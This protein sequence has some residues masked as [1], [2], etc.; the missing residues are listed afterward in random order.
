MPA[1]TTYYLEMNAPS[2]LVAKSDANGLTIIECEESQFQFNR[3]LYQF[4]GG[5]WEWT[6]KLAW[7]DEQW[8]ELVESDAHRTFVAYFN[9]AIAGYFELYRPNDREV[10][11][12][13]FGLAEQFIG[14]GM[15]GYLLS[16]AI[17]SAWNWP[18]TE[19]VWVHTCSLD[20]PSALR[21]YQARGLKIYKEV[22]E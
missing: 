20:H 10:E 16:Q 7:S 19:R 5:A 22:T 1:V 9:G 6:D 17:E 21:N 4:I 3:F 8:K 2:E 18:G 11:I 12:L 14:K 13:Y 15:G